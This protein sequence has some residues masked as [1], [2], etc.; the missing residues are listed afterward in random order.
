M[1][2]EVGNTIYIL[3]DSTI[4]PV[5]MGKRTASFDE[6]ISTFTSLSLLEYPEGFVVAVIPDYDGAL[7][8]IRSMRCIWI[9]TAEMP[10]ITMTHRFMHPSGE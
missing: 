10:M 2:V 3:H 4:I 9:P 8:V 6:F 1:S 5:I 7:G